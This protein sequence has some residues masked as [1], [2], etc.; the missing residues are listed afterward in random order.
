MINQENRK[1]KLS[2]TDPGAGQACTKF[3]S[4][5]YSKEHENLAKTR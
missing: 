5:K 1:V 3:I 4:Y 2:L